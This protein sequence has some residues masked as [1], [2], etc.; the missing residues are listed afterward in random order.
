MV[1]S[2]G[3]AVETRA[4][5]MR[6]NHL[7]KL[8]LVCFVS[9]LLSSCAAYSPRFFSNYESGT[10]SNQQV[11]I[12]WVYYSAVDGIDQILKVIDTDVYEIVCRPSDQRSCWP[13][14]KLVP[15]TYKIS[16]YLHRARRTI[17]QT[18]TIKL[19]PG[20][21]YKIMDTFC[22]FFLFESCMGRPYQGTLWIEDDATG[23]VVAGERWDY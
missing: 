15:G 20:H 7:L 17:S 6:N 23:E 4:K 13:P 11:A 18:D 14:F 9:S 12:V 19:E 5:A 8:V 16:Y 22:Y 1:N 3:A 2:H 10:L 21:S